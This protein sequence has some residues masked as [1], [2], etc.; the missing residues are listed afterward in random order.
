M[1]DSKN[2]I[3]FV[4]L[5]TLA[6]LGLVQTGIWGYTKLTQWV[7]G[8]QDAFVISGK[9]QKTPIVS[10][11]DKGLLILNVPMIYDAWK[12]EAANNANKKPE[13]KPAK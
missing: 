3:Q 8:S 7:P 10:M 12:Q 1:S 11:N 5:I 13:A 6:L 2:K 9:D 4:V